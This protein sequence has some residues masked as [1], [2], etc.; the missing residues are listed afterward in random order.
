MKTQ[1]L[2]HFQYIAVYFRLLFLKFSQ[3]LQ[4][5]LDV[6]KVNEA[7]FVIHQT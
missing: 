7:T 6:P 3:Y 2:V 4:I 1:L 5:I